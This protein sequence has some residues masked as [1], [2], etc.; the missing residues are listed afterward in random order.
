MGKSSG[1]QTTVQKTELPEWLNT[2]AQENLRI[3]GQLASRPYQPYG[4]SVVA[5]F[6]PEQEQAFQMAQANLGA[7]RPALTAATGAA[8][9]GAYYEP[10]QITAPSFL[11]GNIQSYINPYLSEV[12]QRASDALNRQFAQIQN[13]IASQAVQS[14][15]FGGSRRE[16]QEGVAAAEAA[17]AS[18][19]LSARLR[20]EGFQQ[21]AALQQADQARAMQAALA[22]QQ[23]GISGAG[24]GIQGAQALGQLAQQAQG[25]GLADVGAIEAIGAQRQAQQQRA[26]EEAYARFVEQ[27]DFPLQQLN[28]RLA[29]VGATPYGQTQ[30]QTRT[31]GDSGSSFLTG[32]GGVGTFASGIAALAT[33]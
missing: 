16:V 30:T 3:A 24:L 18:G 5:G 12:E 25:A 14:R 1:P 23:A 26:L 31:G 9:Q 29:A 13:Q 17:R 21:A 33:F 28:L 22:N 2:A 6:S 10:Q 20:A 7:Y 32:L 11:T 15:A 4:G 27:R 19:D 8:V